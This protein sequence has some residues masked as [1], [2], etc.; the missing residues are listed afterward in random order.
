MSSLSTA[1]SNFI[2][3]LA[4]STPLN[5]DLV[6][7]TATSIS[8]KWDQPLSNGGIP[9]V[10]FNIYMATGS[11]DYS[12]LTAAAPYTNPTITSYTA[13]S[14]TSGQSYKFK[15][16]SYNALFSSLQTDYIYV[17]ASDLPE[18]PVNAPIINTVSQSTITL[19]LTTIPP[20]NN[21]GSSVTGYIVMMDDGL[22]GAF[23]QIQDSLNT[24]LTISNLYSGRTYRIKYAGR[25]IVYDQNNMFDCDSI[26]FSDSV[27]VL[28][29][30]NPQA[31][32]NLQKDPVLRYKDQIVVEW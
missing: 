27:N 10:G 15:I 7:R 8:F 31:P 2:T 30:V 11:S 22:G 14:L 29:A 3:A 4:P 16:G 19:T 18:K 23:T 6:G 28:T 1:S 17:I 12:L 25:N 5:L 13:S 24:Q 20:A 9:L 26:K 21:G 32:Q